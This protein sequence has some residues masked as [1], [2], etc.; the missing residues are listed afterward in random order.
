MT[1]VEMKILRGLIL[2]GLCHGSLGVA[3]IAAPVYASAISLRHVMVNSY[4]LGGNVSSVIVEL[5]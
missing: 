3:L 2:R 1:V 5:P 4:Q